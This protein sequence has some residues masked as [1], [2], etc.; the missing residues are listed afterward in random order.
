MKI[1]V[2]IKSVYNGF[3]NPLRAIAVI[4]ISDCFIIKSVRLVEGRKGLFV[5]MPAKRNADDEFIEQCHPITAECKRQIDEAVIEA[6]HDFLS[7][8]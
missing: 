8:Q 5:S 7:A 3:K 4:I 2:E 6:Y 1:K